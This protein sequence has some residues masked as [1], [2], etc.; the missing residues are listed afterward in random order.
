MIGLRRMGDVMG[1]ESG[2]V[3]RD[4]GTCRRR[5]QATGFREGASACRMAVGALGV[6]FGGTGLGGGQTMGIMA[7]NAAK[8]PI[9]AEITPAG[10]HLLDM[11]DR[12]GLASG[13]DPR[14]LDENRPDLTKIHTGTEIKV[15]PSITADF[16]D[17]LKMTGIADRL[18]FRGGKFCRIHNWV[19]GCGGGRRT[20]ILD[21]RLAWAMA[22]FAGNRSFPD[23]RMEK[24]VVLSR[25]RIHPPGV[26]SQTTPTHR[27]FESEMVVIGISGREIPAI[28]LRI[29]GDGRHEHHPAPVDEIR[30][31]PL[32]RTDH[33][34][35]FHP[36]VV[37]LPV[38]VGQ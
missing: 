15:G 26:T 29:P 5:G 3:A 9:A 36:L 6:E 10:V 24:P 37:N 32:P 13:I 8:F 28:L 4:T 25:F 20:V 1:A 30:P 14:P 11:A 21:V 17:S 33:E 38:R 35:D 34:L 18:A 19:G 22:A 31:A 7:G 27:P 23:G 12:G 2:H 16:V